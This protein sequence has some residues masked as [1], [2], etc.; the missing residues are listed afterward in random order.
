[1]LT[2]EIW[3]QN[4][5]EAPIDFALVSVIVPVYNHERFICSCLESVAGETYP[6]MELIVI[7]DGSTDD[8][9]DLATDWAKISASRFVRVE[10]SK[11]QNSGLNC[12]LNR[13]IRMARGEFIVILASDDVLIA[14]GILARV[15]ALLSNPQ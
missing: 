11:Q 6:R 15:R 3:K 1:L 9:F 5:V 14:G 10:V 12:T 13:L 4:M 7:D 8:S 2:V